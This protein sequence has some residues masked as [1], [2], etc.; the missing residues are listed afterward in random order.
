VC[1]RTPCARTLTCAG[2]L[3]RVPAHPSLR[4]VPAHSPLRWQLRTHPCVGRPCFPAH[5]H[6]RDC[7]LR[8]CLRTPC[9]RTLTCA[10]TLRRVP[11][12]PSLRRVPA[13]S[14]LRWQL[15]THPCVGRPCFPAHRYVRDGTLRVCLRTPCART[16]TCAGTLRRVP[17]HPFPRTQ[18]CAGTLRA[19]GSRTPAHS[20]CGY[21]WATWI[22]IAVVDN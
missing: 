19:Q 3:R 15:S 6:V 2:T 17:A 7:T 20:I 8:V 11:A 18:P 10:G 4:R 22:G 16:L 1:L 5:R 9:A 21:R 12:H 13:H 14:P